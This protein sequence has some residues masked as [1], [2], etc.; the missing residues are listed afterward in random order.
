MAAVPE[1]S[2]QRAVRSR[3][4]DATVTRRRTRAGYVVAW[5]LCLAAAAHG[6]ARSASAQAVP[7]VVA[8]DDAGRLREITPGIADRLGLRPPSW[9]VEG[10]YRRARLLR[11]DAGWVL[12][13][14]R[15]DGRLDSATLTD[16]Q[17]GTIRLDVSARASS[18]ARSADRPD[19]V[20]RR[21]DTPIARRDFV[22]RE[23]LLGAGL[24]GPL[25]WAAADSRAFSPSAY[26]FT[27]AGTFLL[28]T[29]AI[30]RTS[31]GR[32][33]TTIG[34]FAALGGAA[35][36]AAVAYATTD[37][38]LRGQA[39][40]AL[41]GGVGLHVGALWW[42]EAAGPADAAGVLF[43]S[44]AGA[45]V[46]AGALG[47][48]GAFDAPTRDDRRLTAGVLATTTLLGAPLGRA[49]ATRRG[50]RV[51]DGDVGAVAIAGGLGAVLGLGIAGGTTAAAG[52]RYLWPTALG[53]A[54]LVAG[55]RLLAAPFD[56]DTADLGTL[57]VGAVAGAG[58]AALPYWLAG[59]ANERTLLILAA[60]GGMV[61]VWGGEV[62]ARPRAGTRV[63]RGG[64]VG[65]I[66][67]ARAGGPRVT[68]NAPALLFAAM[69]QP[70][71][72]PVVRVTF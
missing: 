34:T 60:V 31:Y 6:A 40:A 15:F 42:A 46:G 57:A 58:I 64:G 25:A 19:A 17:V 10:E 53:V 50:A 32:A 62:V 29:N 33:Q 61:G 16:E 14:Q 27:A 39:I 41:A 1:V 24:F 26:L 70:G 5:W 52:P 20:T 72:F 21:S 2:P 67:P 54:G 47:A 66:G 69:R 55:D 11:G 13:V 37:A 38:G 9:P 45:L 59:N 8:F 3:A 30:N 56:H 49:Y 44:V 18:L 35:A 12:E 68:F 43:G 7:V 65:Q 4:R 48:T 51:T 63:G 36:G 23:A 22:R 71:I 28:A